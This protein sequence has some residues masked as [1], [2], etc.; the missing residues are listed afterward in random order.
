ML[1]CVVYISVVVS[2]V[3]KKL[4]LIET[5]YDSKAKEE[6]VLESG[7]YVLSDDFDD[8]INFTEKGSFQIDEE[9][10]TLVRNKY[11]I[12]KEVVLPKTLKNDCKRYNCI[13]F[14]INFD[15]IN[16]LLWKG[17]IGIEDFRFLEHDGI[18]FKSLLRAFIADVKAM[19]KV[20][21]GS[22]LT[23][24]LAK[25][26]FLTNEKKIERKLREM[27]YASYIEYKLPKEKIIT[28]YFNE[29]FWGVVGGVYI[30]GIKAASIAYFDKSP[31][32]LTDYESSILI[33]ML[34]GPYFYSPTKHLDRL[35]RRTSVVFNRLKS[36]SLVGSSKDTVWTEEKWKSWRYKLDKKS[37]RKSIRSY[38]N[39]SKSLG[40][41]LEPFEKFVFYQSI[42]TIN[43]ELEKQTKGLDIATK[44]LALEKTCTEFPCPQSFYHY[45]KPERNLDKAINLEKHQVGSVLK[46]I[47]YE[48]L[49]ELGKNL[50][51]KVSTKPITLKLVSGKWTPKDSSKVKREF[52][53]L[54]Y[55]V[56]KSKNIPL[57]RVANE[58]GFSKLEP[59]LLEYFPDLL[60][61]LAEYPAQLLGSIE[62][63]LS[64]L[65]KSY[66]KYF[67]KTCENIK[68]NKY[69]FEESILFEMSKAKETT[70]S[71]VSSKAINDILMFGK[72]GTTNDGLDNW[73]IAF[74]G[75][76]FYAIWFGVD[77]KRQGKKLRLAGAT[78]AY[79]IFQNFQIYRGKQLYELYCND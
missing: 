68:S 25:N 22:T 57:I 27:V 56:K 67:K 9:A 62:M 64:E 40:N 19:K 61:P 69:T 36:L 33:G 35:Q 6:S 29:I 70:I 23:M 28:T 43:S 10:M 59:K 52:V 54:R 11:L 16:P 72:T 44:F 46:P 39:L 42:T 41:F 17:L 2:E 8:F 5:E 1:S 4:Q 38:Y 58:I 15:N 76:V 71:R 78:S 21:G 55:A 34:K 31:D 7:T 14:N 63:S 75:K 48:Q 20:Q 65:G 74:D 13:K 24:Q 3:H 60:T 26:L 37:K 12:N 73:Y 50:S 47:I 53:E 79:R 51:D 18:D 32:E 30:K 45:T 66:L 49:V 77:S